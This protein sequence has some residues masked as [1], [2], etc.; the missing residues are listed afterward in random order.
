MVNEQMQVAQIVLDHSECAGVL[1][2]YRIDYC[3]KGDLPLGE[4]C[5]KRGA[6]VQAVLADLAG[7]IAERREPPGIDPREVPTQVLVDHIVKRHHRYLKESLPFLAPLA[8]KVARVHG[9]H[10]GNLLGLSDVVEELSDALI[11]HIEREEQVLF[12]ALVN[13]GKP[14]EIVSA[15][16]STMH[17]GHLEVSTMLERLR[18]FAQ[19]FTVPDWACTSYTTLFRELQTME[20]DIFQHVHLENHVLMPRFARPFAHPREN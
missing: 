9:A 18:T 16:L 11:P 13:G 3:C 5:Q 14:R 8:K 20:A 7:A 10:N 4:A 1:M 19:D 17:E 6:D 2:R 12:P 15:E